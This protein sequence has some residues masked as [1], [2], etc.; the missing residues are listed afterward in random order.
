MGQARQGK[1]FLPETAARFLIGETA[2]GQHFNGNVA[3]QT[4]VTSSVNDAHASGANLFCY[5]IT[6]KTQLIHNRAL[7]TER[8]RP[9]D[10]A[11]VSAPVSW[12][13]AFRK[14]PVATP[15]MVNTPM[16]HPQS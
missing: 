15:L 11:R 7:L 10:S 3:V 1:R 5:L 12:H 2:G 16:D 6:A 8:F 9:R 14:G 4:L 13:A